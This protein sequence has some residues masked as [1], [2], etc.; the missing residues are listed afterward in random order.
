[1]NSP[2]RRERGL[3]VN[4]LRLARRPGTVHPAFSHPLVQTFAPVFGE[5]PVHPALRVAQSVISGIEI[6]DQCNPAVGTVQFAD[7]VRRNR[8]KSHHSSVKLVGTVSFALEYISN[9]MAESN[10]H[11]LAGRGITTELEGV[12]GDLA[13]LIERLK[14]RAP[15]RR[16]TAVEAVERLQWIRDAP[17][18]RIRRF[19]AAA[20]VAAV[21]LGAAK[22]T[23]DL[24]RERTAAVSARQD[25]DRRRTQAESLIGFMLGNLRGKLQQAGRLEL[26]EDVGREA[27]TYFSNSPR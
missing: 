13:K 12:S 7:V 1:M 27:T 22:Y 6:K 5:E 24:A 4:H 17:K 18:R 10:F 21:V 3:S 19:A 9:V 8:L 20:L 14:S 25:A 16:P 23:I 2:L 15:T 26:L 11:R